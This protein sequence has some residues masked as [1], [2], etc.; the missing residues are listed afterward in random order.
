MEEPRR[1]QSMGSQRVGHDGLTKHRGHTHFSGSQTL[2]TI[3]SLGR[4]PSPTLPLPKRQA[5]LKNEVRTYLA[6]F[7]T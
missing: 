6:P 5:T 4:V 2:E 1:L 7:I 3:E